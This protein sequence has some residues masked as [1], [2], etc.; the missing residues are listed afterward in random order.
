M[1]WYLSLI[2]LALCVAVGRGK[3][4][5]QVS[6]EIQRKDLEYLKCDVCKRVA[7]E[8]NE[9]IQSR[10]SNKPILGEFEIV[11]I[12]D[13]VCKPKNLTTGSWTRKLD[14]V[15]VTDNNKTFLELSEPGGK[16]E[17]RRECAT[18]AK[19]C[20]SL[21]ESEIDADDLSAYLYRSQASLDSLEV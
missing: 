21:M 10:R 19:S 8:L 7:S 11:Q 20:D 5:D 4:I 14:I 3:K 18:L 15:E 17:C 12:M 6:S 1:Y 2:V 16:Q 9:A 13:T